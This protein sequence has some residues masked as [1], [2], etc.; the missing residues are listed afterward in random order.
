MELK[1]TCKILLDK[2]TPL[3]VKC[4]KFQHKDFNREL[5]VHE[6]SDHKTLTTITDVTSG[7]RLCG[8]NKD[9]KHVTEADI[10][11]TLSTFTKHF[12]LDGILHRFKELD[13]N[14]VQTK[15]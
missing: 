8:I 5:A 4:Y 3:K 13:E 6:N 7:M 11:E 1:D 12:T 9:V 2:G 14:L 15:K 10:K